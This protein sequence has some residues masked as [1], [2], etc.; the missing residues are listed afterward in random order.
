MVLP[1][2]EDVDAPVQ[3]PEGV[4]VT[5]LESIAAPEPFQQEDEA[6]AAKVQQLKDEITALWLHGRERRL[7]LGRKFR[8]LQ[9]LLARRG[10]GTFLRTVSDPPPQ[11]LGIPVQTMYGYI[12]EADEA[13]RCYEI[14]NN[15]A[16]TETV[17]AATEANAETTLSDP[18]AEQVFAAKDAWRQRVDE[19][20]NRNRF[21]L[22][23]RV[24]FAPVTPAERE[25]CKER[26]K[27][28][29]S[30]KAFELFRGA[31][32]AGS[33]TIAVEA[34]VEPEAAPEAQLA[35]ADCAR[36]PD[37]EEVPIESAGD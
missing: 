17:S 25:R 16:D 30:A 32:F 27:E 9:K 23:Y 28:L 37:R 35:H 26:F 5:D 12:H 10:R 24:D 6:D 15:Y 8:E 3:Q 29:G 36:E 19:L 13:D 21:S 2:L 34:A 31:L 7:A 22:L 20:K 11:G 1:F 4:I 18:Q 14:G 33:E